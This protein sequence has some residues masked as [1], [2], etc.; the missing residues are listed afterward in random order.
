MLAYD[1]PKWR[2]LKGGYKIPY[3][4]TP[5]LR[6]LE[7][8]I[9]TAAAWDELWQELHHQGDIGEASYAAI[10][11]LVR[12]HYETHALDWNLY[13]LAAVIEIERHRK[14][15]PP[16][17]SWL[18]QDYREAWKTLLNLAIDDLRVAKDET[19]VEASLGVIALGKGLLTLG[20]VISNF[21]EDERLEILDTYNSWSETYQQVEALS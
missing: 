13:G 6:K 12:I 3:D 4:P 19:T 17:P 7:S 8:G 16:L 11:H 2:E 14:T 9:D 20:V 1:D 15:N 21:T 5:A 18:A 10:P